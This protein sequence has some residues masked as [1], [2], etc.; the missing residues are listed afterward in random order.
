MTSPAELKSQVNRKTFHLILLE[1]VTC[2][3][4]QLI[5]MQKTNQQ[6]RE[7]TGKA[8][9]SET[10][11]IWLCV[12]LGLAGA[13][14][15]TGDPSVNA[16]CGLLAIIRIVMNIVWAFKAR[17]VLLDYAHSHQQ[18]QFTMNP[19]YTLLFNT[20]H[21]NYCINALGDLDARQS[22]YYQQTAQ[23]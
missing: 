10:Y 15:N 18:P 13:F 20:Y 22:P 8:V 3:L 14:A 23:A 7:A 6:L 16:L 19:L 12:C 9:S 17:R 2:L 21:I 1:I 5:W 11:I 4:Y